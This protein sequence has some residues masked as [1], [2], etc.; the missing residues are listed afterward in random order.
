MVD[1]SW[2]DGSRS[3]NAPFSHVWLRDNCLCTA[4]LHPKTRQRQVDTLQVPPPQAFIPT[5]STITI[6]GRDAEHGVIAA[7]R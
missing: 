7:R 4:C 3:E 2:R 6:G 5:F 1:V